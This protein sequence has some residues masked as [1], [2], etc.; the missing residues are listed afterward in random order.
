VL[1]K[2]DERVRILMYTLRFWAKRAGFS[3][4]TLRVT[5]YALFMMLYFYLQNTQPK[6]LSTVEQLADL[7][8]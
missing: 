4:H 1:V 3:D 2:Q 8:G 6:V 5:S 7:A